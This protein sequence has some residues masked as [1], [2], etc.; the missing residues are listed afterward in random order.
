MDIRLYP[1]LSVLNKRAAAEQPGW[2]S[3]FGNQLAE[4]FTGAAHYWSGGRIGS[5]YA[6]DSTWI[7][8]ARRVNNAV[9]GTAK[10][11]LYYQ[12]D[13]L[14]DAAAISTGVAG[15]AGG[16]AGIAAGAPA[17]L[18]G[19]SAAL[20]A[21]PAAGS[22]LAG[23]AVRLGAPV[24]AAATGVVNHP[25][26]QQAANFAVQQ[27]RNALNNT[28]SFG[29]DVLIPGRQWI[30]D[31]RALMQYVRQPWDRAAGIGSNLNAA[32]T[33][34]GLPALTASMGYDAWSNA[35]GSALDKYKD[36]GSILGSIY[37]G[38]KGVVA[39]APVSP[40]GGLPFLG[41]ITAAGLQ[42]NEQDIRSQLTP[43]QT[44]ELDRLANSRNPEEFA[45]SQQLL[46]ATAAKQS[47]TLNTLGQVGNKAFNLNP[48][49]GT[50]YRDQKYNRELTNAFNANKAQVA[51][52][53]SG[54]ENYANPND[55]RL[56]AIKDW[57][58]SDPNYVL[59]SQLL[60]K[61]AEYDA[62]LNKLYASDPAKAQALHDSIVNR[63]GPPPQ[64]AATPS[65]YPTVQTAPSSFESIP[66]SDAKPN[67]AL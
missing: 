7:D 55:P 65:T 17:V 34:I 25:R 5:D 41:A 51:S 44:E 54:L 53:Q 59:A 40:L 30:Q 33:N 64:T 49:Q 16:A 2:W 43:E 23:T 10:Q 50:S 22:A 62:T 67:G 35:I 47:P 26:T 4:P 63:L 13:K 36:T 14:L 20:N 27:G 3:T 52:I 1:I 45:R 15:L 42:P 19:G 12:N 6:D 37:E 11:P 32:V 9:P 38:G 56:Q 60:L 29:R 21:A 24:A 28:Y 58:P 46:A 18:A 39:N 57:N 48:W 66:G 31:P 61:P 8:T